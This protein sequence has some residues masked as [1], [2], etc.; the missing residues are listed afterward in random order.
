MRRP[1]ICLLLTLGLL[2][3]S[4]GAQQSP[5]PQDTSVPLP[6][7]VLPG[8]LERVLRDYERAWRASDVQALVALFTPD[9]FVLQPG[10]PPA[11]GHAALATVYRGQGGGVLRLRALAYDMA[12]SVGYIIGAYGSGDDPAD[13]GKF[14]LTLRRTAE[15]RWLIVSDMD[16]GSRGDPETA[17]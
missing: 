5:P 1:F 13:L 6:S 12:G 7:I 15:G 17:A 11:R 4:L 9:G 10:R 16:N 3:P 2:A 14:T 8:E